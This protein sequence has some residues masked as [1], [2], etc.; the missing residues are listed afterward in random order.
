MK[1]FPSA[2]WGK[3]PTP[4]RCLRGVPIDRDDLLSECP[5]GAERGTERTALCRILCEASC[6]H[7]GER[8][9]PPR[10]VG[11]R[12]LKLPKIVMRRKSVRA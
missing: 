3:A 7:C 4:G 11:A 6:R 1:P 5:F 12:R 2:A 8:P 9:Q 10:L